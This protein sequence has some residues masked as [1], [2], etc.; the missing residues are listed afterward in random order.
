MQ[1]KL[2]NLPLFLSHGGMIALDS[3]A[4][5]KNSLRGFTLIEML[6][7]I[8]IIATLVALVSVAAQ[9]ALEKARVTQDMNNLRQIGLATQMYMNDNDGVIFSA[10][11]NADNWMAQLHP[12]YL[13]SWKVFQSPFDKRAASESDATAPVSYG[14]NGN[15]NIGTAGVTGMLAD[16][17]TNPSAF[18]LFAPAQTQG[19]SSTVAFSGTA[20]QGAPGVTV[21]KGRSTPGGSSLGATPHG[22]NNGRTRIN[23]VFADMHTENM[24]WTR[25]IN[26][27]Q[28]DANDP[29]AK[30]RWDP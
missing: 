26:D 6:I 25:F 20:A 9:S 21:Y 3:L 5:Q 19:K 15:T 23:A 17:I 7:V 16:K 1:L 14:L 18:I 29:D 28:N 30:Y 24:M 12:K 8:A 4:M 13:P 22:T 10:D 2:K 11:A 27:S